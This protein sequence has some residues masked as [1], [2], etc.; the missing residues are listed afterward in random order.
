MRS[1]N[2]S[3]N[4]IRE[5][6]KELSTKFE[7][8][9]FP[10]IGKIPVGLANA[11]VVFPAAIGVGSL[12]CSYYLGQ[13]IS[14]RLIF[15]RIFKKLHPER[16]FD[17]ELYPVWVDP[18]DPKLFQY[19]RLAMFFSL[20]SLILLL[21]IYLTFSTLSNSGYSTNSSFLGVSENS[22]LTIAISIGFLLTVLGVYIIIKDSHEYC[23]FLK[24]KNANEQKSSDPS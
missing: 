3:K 18:M 11:V 13:T 23:S 10:V 22:I 5:G 4:Q 9:E 24:Q 20:P 2:D 15:H 12:I 21:I 14:K 19:G 16:S 8:V 17:G 1:L 6:I 7:E